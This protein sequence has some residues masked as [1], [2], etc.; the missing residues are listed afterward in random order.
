MN[1]YFKE[2]II[3]IAGTELIV[4][5]E[6]IQ[7]LWSG[8]GRIQRFFFKGG[9]C[10]SLVVKHISYPE[11]MNH[12][13]GWNTSVSHQRKLHSYQVEIEWYKNWRN[14]CTNNCYAPA[15]L[16]VA[17][18]GNEILIVLEDLNST[19]FPARAKALALERME[20]CLSWLAHFHAIYMHSEPVG[21]WP[22]GTYWHLDTRPDELK[23][24]TDKN[25]K[26]A[27]PGIDRVLNHTKHKTLVHGDAKLANFCFSDD[28]KKVAAVDFQ[29]VGGGCGMKDVA[30]FIGSCLYE[31]DCEKY[32]V[33]LLNIYFQ[34]LKDAISG[35]Q[36]GV[37]FDKLEQEW[38]EMYPYAWA[39]FHRFLKGWSPGHW[40]INSYS[41]KMTRRVIQDLENR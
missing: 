14:R 41:E 8:Y 13:R 31:E 12:P 20:I 16:G 22:I 3:R 4:K 29:Y 27:A 24:L 26:Q 23:L 30:Y 36:Q 38:R 33:Q 40:K 2:E 6:D 32:E 28:M 11:E 25:L 1:S 39:D 34:H 35:S 5:V 10:S 37:N 19:G 15:C 7:S 17:Q 21:L 18:Q 9:N